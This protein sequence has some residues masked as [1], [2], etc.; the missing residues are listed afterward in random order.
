MRLLESPSFCELNLE[1]DDDLK[2]HSEIPQKFRILEFSFL[3]VIPFEDCPTKPK[4]RIISKRMISGNLLSNRSIKGFRVTSQTYV[5]R[6][7]YLL[8]DQSR[9]R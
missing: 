5:R 4:N 6:S 1:V 8:E 7:K 3:F 9:H 2:Y